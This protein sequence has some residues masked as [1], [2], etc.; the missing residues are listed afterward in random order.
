MSDGGEPPCNPA[1]PIVSARS[2]RSRN[3]DRPEAMLP[4]RP[5][6][7]TAPRISTQKQSTISPKDQFSK[8]HNASGPL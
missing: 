4:I 6:D 3:P 5:L 7:Q 1:P 8:S 2:A